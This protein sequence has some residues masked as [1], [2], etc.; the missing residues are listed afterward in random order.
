MARTIPEIP[1]PIVSEWGFNKAIA[2]ALAFSFAKQGRQIPWER[3][4]YFMGALRTA[5][6][7]SLLF[8]IFGPWAETL[9]Q[10]LTQLYCN[11]LGMDPSLR[12]AT[13]RSVVYWAMVGMSSSCL[14]LEIYFI[15]VLRIYS[16][17]FADLVSMAEKIRGR[18]ARLAL[19]ER[20]AS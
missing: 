17:E 10:G 12:G 4:V 5:F 9:L 20:T 11:L 14:A 18:Y 3:E 7:I 2:A 13:V 1:D 6:G 15:K 8:S 19:T 16:P